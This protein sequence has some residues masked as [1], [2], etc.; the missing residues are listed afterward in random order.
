[1]KKS[2]EASGDNAAIVLFTRYPVAGRVK[3]RLIATLG[4][5]GAASLQQRMTE[6][7]LRQARAT[8]VRVQIRFT[9]AP[10][11]RMRAWLGEAYDYADQG[12]GD[13]GERMQRAF[14]A[15]FRG[16][17]TSVI[18]MGC[19][20]PDNRAANLAA[21]LRLLK[22]HDCVIG[23]A[24]DGGYYLIGLSRSRPE[25]F[26]DMPWGTSAVLAKTLAVAGACPLLDT[27]PDIDRPAD[28]PPRISVIVPTL[29]EAANIERCLYSVQRGFAIECL[30]VDGGSRDDTAAVARRARAAVVASAP[31]RA[32]QMNAG[33][34]L[35]TGD[36]LLF[37]HADSELPD[38]WDRHVRQ[39][40]RDPRTSLGYFR[41]KIRENL[42]GRRWLER[43]TNLRARLRGRPYGDQGLFVRK[44]TFARLGGFPDVPI[45]E[46]LLFVEMAKKLGR[47]QQIAQPLITSG[48]RWA[49]YGMVRTTLLNQIILAA[50]A[51]G[52]DPHALKAAY[53]KGKIPWG[54]LFKR[55]PAKST[56]TPRR[57]SGP[58]DP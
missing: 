27:L 21:C 49:Q 8:G 58:P 37:L 38:E 5:Q 2:P 25:L 52:A 47:L 45:L 42:P 51:M 34:A 32:A 10:L 48:R 54:L 56:R 31:G 18:V 14:D 15:A 36:I 43:G 55:P 50:A 53:A 16:G 6:F 13:L 35:A 44:D 29:N 4:A 1:M 17:A 12:G 28:L 3:T 26:R 9:G 7:A 24:C 46:D 11:E 19:D 30:V 20:C 40:M 57:G 39:A 33:A 23:P 41:F 22:K